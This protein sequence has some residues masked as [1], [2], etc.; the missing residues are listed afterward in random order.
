M[1][2]DVAE[3]AEQ[4][5]R[6][7]K[8]EQRSADDPRQRLFGRPEV[9]GDIADRYGEHGDGEAGREQTGKGGDEYP[10]AVAI[11]AADARREPFPPNARPV[12]DRY[13]FGAGK[14]TGERV[15]GRARSVRRLLWHGRRLERPISVY[16]GCVTSSVS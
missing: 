3:L 2:V 8:G 11:A 5:H 6:N 1:A 12:E 13:F 4:R 9:V 15:I 16:A 10:A 7:R 14:L